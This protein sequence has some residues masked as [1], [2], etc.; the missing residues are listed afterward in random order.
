[1]LIASYR[2]ATGTR[3][4][5]GVVGT[6]RIRD[7]LVTRLRDGSLE[8]VW[9]GFN[10][11]THTV[12]GARQYI[13]WLGGA[14]M[15]DDLLPLTFRATPGA[16]APGQGPRLDRVR[17]IILEVST[18]SVFRVGPWVLQENYF[19]ELFVRRFGA[20]ML[21][22]YRSVAARNPD[23][24]LVA[25]ETLEKLQAEGKKLTHTERDVLFFTRFRQ[26][27]TAEL[28]VQ[29][30]TMVAALPARWIVVTHFTLPDDA[31]ATMQQRAQMMEQVR[32]AATA[33]GAEIFDPTVLIRH[34]GRKVAIANDGA[35]IYHYAPDF[36]AVVGQAL[37]DLIRS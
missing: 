14:E 18:L 30:K 13:D 20:P 33:A 21:P 31:S 28:T 8:K 32:N 10:A 19:F 17:T 24:K 5:I 26:D 2:D 12:E 7:P 29:L 22:W 25:L 9:D 35:D 34:H 36:N 16:V 23:H 6:C 15:P 1:M 11:F 3:Q 27:T 4:Q 37:F